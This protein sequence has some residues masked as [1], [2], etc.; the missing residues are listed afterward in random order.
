MKKAVLLVWPLLLACG[1]IPAQVFVAKG[2]LKVGLTVTKEDRLLPIDSLCAGFD[3]VT[4]L[5]IDWVVPR[6]SS[7]GLLTDSI[8]AEYIALVINSQEPRRIYDPAKTTSGFSMSSSAGSTNSYTFIDEIKGDTLHIEW[9]VGY[10]RPELLDLYPADEFVN[11]VSYSFQNIF[12]EYPDSARYDWSAVGYIS[13]L[14][15]RG[16]PIAP[17]FPHTEN[18]FYF[19]VDGVT[20]A[21][22]VEL[23]GYHEAPQTVDPD[24]PYDL[25]LYED[26]AP[27]AYELIVRPYAEAP[28]SL[29]LSYPFTIRK[30]WWQ[31]T[32]GI[33]GITLLIAFL[34]GA[35]VL[36][37]YRNRA[38][39]RAREMQW[40]Q[41]LTEAE[42]KAIRA[43]LNPHFL[44]NSLSSIQ[45]L[46]AQGKNERANTYLVKLSR[47]LRQVLAASER[48]FQELAE[49]LQLITWYLEIEQLRYPFTFA[50]EVAETVDRHS[51][52]P[53][54]LL[55]PYV[56]NAVKHGVAG[57]PDGGEVTIRVASDGR[58]LDF[59]I[60]DNGP[61]LAVANGQSTG[62]QLGRDRLHYLTDRYS[63]AAT[64]VVDNREDTSGVIVKIS[65]PTA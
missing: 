38:R 42:L 30:P 36:A 50:I 33:I 61:G 60:L 64:V 45:N 5:P 52:V 19:V 53:V 20:D 2:D 55:Q 23:K 21:A 62:L 16:L 17:R 54:M 9:K 29:W 13:R 44:F 28:E 51:L 11:Y 10:D 3:P 46:V 40:K 4:H 32:Y 15:D 18:G 1:H 58:K 12:G 35:T 37:G 49:E 39:R 8:R 7:V 25:F 47:L 59:T 41:Q 31:R 65:L 57:N 26:L 22:V 6:G 34:I 48:Q 63:E 27:G 24:N 43:Q 14:D 56:E